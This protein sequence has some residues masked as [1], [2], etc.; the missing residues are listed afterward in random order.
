MDAPRPR[1]WRSLVHDQ[2]VSDVVLVLACLALTALAVKASWAGA[3]RPVIAVAGIV[4]SLAQWPRRRWPLVAAV[5]GALTYPF[6]G[7]PGPL[8]VGLY[9]GASYT[10]P[11][12]AWIPFALGWAGFAGW[13]LVDEGRLDGDDALF[14]TFAAAFVVGVGVYTAARRASW[15][16]RIARAQ[17]ERLLHDEQARAAERDRIAREMHDVLAHKVSLIALHAG[18]LEIGATGDADR[19]REG[20][21]LIRATAREAL[22]ELRGVLGM[23]DASPRP[24]EE[25]FADL[26]TLVDAATTAGQRVE[27]R[28][29]AGTLPPATARVVYRVAQEGLTNARKHA[30]EARATV[31]VDR[32]GDDVTVTVHNGPG[33]A[34]LNLPG[35]GA[36]LVGLAERIRLAGGDLHGGPVDDGWRL[37]A[38]FPVVDEPRDNTAPR[39]ADAR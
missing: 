13:S 5:A 4:G 33:G 38:A 18:A 7:N 8:L 24:A 34:A 17:A 1:D 32:T 39:A 3:P 22:Q 25:P 16:A 2:R 35:S 6:S 11:S 27:L 14:A 15:Q 9:A 36:G 19:T 31:S 21:A 20:A 28:D 37:T 12:R 30:P 10:R 29:H 26:S 23:L